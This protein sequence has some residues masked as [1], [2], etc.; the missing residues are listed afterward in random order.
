MKKIYN[1][2]KALGFLAAFGAA[3]L[4]AQT[5][6]TS[7]AIS[8]YDD[9]IFN[10]TLGTLNNTSSCGQLAG[11][12]GSIAYRYSNY[13]TVVPAPNLLMGN[14][15][16]LSVTGGQCNGF[17]YC[18]YIYVW[19]DYNQNGSFTD[20]GEMVWTSNYTCWAPGGTPASAPGGITIPFTALPG[21]TRMRVVQAEGSTSGPCTQYGYG[22]TEDYN[23]NI[24][25][26]PPC[27]GVPGANAVIT[28]TYA[29]CPNAAALLTLANTYSTYG[30]T[31]QWQSSTVSAVG[32]Y[33]SIPNATL[34][35]YVTP[36]LTANTFYQAVITC[37][38]SNSSTITASGQVSIQPVVTSNVPY[39]EG[40]ENIVNT[41]DLPNCSWSASNPVATCRTY[42]AT[43]NQQ[44]VAR[45]GSKFASFYYSPSGTNYFYTNGIQLNAGVTYSASLWYATNYY[46]ETNWSD[47]SILYGSSQS[48][49]GL[50]S[51]VSSNGPAA[52]N[53]YKSLANTFTVSASGIYYIAIR[54]TTSGCCAYHLNWDDLLI[55]AP[56]QLNTPTVTLNT[57]TTTICEGEPVNI[58]AAGADS[59]VWAHGPTTAQIN[60]TPANS[61]FYTVVGTNTAAGCSYTTTQYIN[62]LPKP[63]LT[64]FADKQVVCAG[65][66]VNI[67]VSGASTYTWSTGSNSSFITV[68]P[69]TGTSYTC[70]GSS[71]L[72]CSAV[73]SQ[74]VAVNALPV[75]TGSTDKA[76]ICR[77]ESA[78]LT[79]GGAVSYA[80]SSSSIFVQSA[81]AVVAPVVNT[82]FILSGTDANGCTN[83]VSVQQNVQECLGVNE[84]TSLNGVKLYPNPTA[85]IFTI[86]LKNGKDK[87]IS[88]LDVTGRLI[89]TA[90]EKNDLVK[91]DISS[92]SHG[93]YYVRIQ[94]ENATDVIKLVKN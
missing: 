88:V 24:V 69:T 2:F 92:L 45:T 68:N 34:T 46:G 59:Y 51:I 41:N 26:P 57:S 94:S 53:G 11:G 22:E 6:C 76:E 56:C 40:F 83:T 1:Y 54:G 67:S 13:T 39:F 32:P 9:E 61:T 23:V 65:K 79:G 85:G 49:T 71:A 62:V 50:V 7:N 81:V 93:I 8:T 77:G 43:Q 89:L 87:T 19:I 29:I 90:T 72:G 33:V 20:P 80:W 42:T 60:E 17:T 91:V 37:T 64:I 18:G 16:P 84:V 25:L 63:V 58:T 30:F 28:P 74:S 3:P 5:Y 12:A 82:T 73:M 36:S 15:Y 66:P 78:T 27:S 70:I 21:V 86:E 4:A 52:S 47:M 38:N 44:R 31:Y 14:N 10:V 75:V 48:T 35:T 55:E